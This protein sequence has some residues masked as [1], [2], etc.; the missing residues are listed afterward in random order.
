MKKNTNVIRQ[1]SGIRSLEHLPSSCS[2][3]VL[4]A[5]VPPPHFISATPLTEGKVLRAT[6]KQRISAVQITLSTANE[7]S[8]TFETRSDIS[9]RFFF[10]EHRDFR[11]YAVLA[12]A[13]RCALTIAV[14]AKGHRS[15]CRIWIIPSG[16][17][18]TPTLRR[19]ELELSRRAFSE[20][21]ST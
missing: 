4:N 3:L 12:D 16:C 18:T 15:C 20:L 19:L 6:T 21:T 14:H 17:P 13:P 10:E 11:T 5:C 9:D 7:Q 2:R 8:K 1:R